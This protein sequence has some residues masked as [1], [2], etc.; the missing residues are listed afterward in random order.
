MKKCIDVKH[1]PSPSSFL[2]FLFSSRTQTHQSKVITHKSTTYSRPPQSNQPKP[3]IAPKAVDQVAAVTP[4][5]DPHP[6]LHSPPEFKPRYQ[7]QSP[8]QS[9]RNGNIDLLSL[10]WVVI[11][12]TLMD[13][14]SDGGVRYEVILSGL[15][16]LV[17]RYL[18]LGFILSL[19]SSGSWDFGWNGLENEE[20]GSGG[21]L[22]CS[23]IRISAP[24]LH[25]DGKWEG[26]WFDRIQFYGDKRSSGVWRCDIRCMGTDDWIWT[27]VVRI[28]ESIYACIF[29]RS[30]RDIQEYLYSLLSQTFPFHS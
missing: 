23:G 16:S 4:P 11:F 8:S 15:S 2:P 26:V 17:S 12:E 14:S 22:V 29:K 25:E 27:S 3:H 28:F 9:R 30:L 10:T 18:D 1:N 21:G 5:H 6:Y 7:S 13:G 24:G 20:N 19:F